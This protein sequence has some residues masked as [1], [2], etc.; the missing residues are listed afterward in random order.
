MTGEWGALPLIH[1]CRFYKTRGWYVARS[2]IP[3]AHRLLEK[4]D[5]ILRLDGTSKEADEDVR[6]AKEKVL[7][8]YYNIEDVP[9]A[10]WKSKNL[11]NEGFMC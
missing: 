9:Y 2:S 8:I 4:S 5:D 7:K 10:E 6:I 3:V 1:V 11:R